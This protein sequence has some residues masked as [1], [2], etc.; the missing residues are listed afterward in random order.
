[1]LVLRGHFPLAFKA[2]QGILKGLTGLHSKE[3]SGTRCG[4]EDWDIY[5][6]R[7][8]VFEEHRHRRVNQVLTTCGG[9]LLAQGTRTNVPIRSASSR[10]ISSKPVRVR[11]FML[12]P[13]ETG[14]FLLLSELPVQFGKVLLLPATVV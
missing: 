6:L 10:P 12:A 8:H 2:S 5:L 7:I 14:L 3:L 9:I 4:D 11:S 13:L 1:L